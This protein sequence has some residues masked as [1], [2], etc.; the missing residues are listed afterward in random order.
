MD[1]NDFESFLPPGQQTTA[2]ID[3]LAAQVT[4]LTNMVGYLIS[5]ANALYPKAGQRVQWED[6]TTKAGITLEGTSATAV[7]DGVL[8]G[9]NFIPTGPGTGTVLLVVRP[10]GQ[11]SVTVIDSTKV[12]FVDE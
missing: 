4:E 12:R 11:Q 2:T 6:K 8:L 5:F 9:A 7:S 10:I 1:H 3:R